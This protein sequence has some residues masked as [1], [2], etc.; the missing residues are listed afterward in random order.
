M[1]CC[2]SATAAASLA[3]SCMPPTSRSSSVVG[4][5]VSGWVCEEKPGW[6]RHR[7]SRP[8]MPSSASPAQLWPSAAL[9]TSTP[10]A[11]PR[12]PPLPLTLHNQVGKVAQQ[13]GRRGRRWG[14]M[15]GCVRHCRRTGRDSRTGARARPASFC[16]PCPAPPRPPVHLRREGAA[17]EVHDAQRAVAH[18]VCMG[19]GGWAGG[20]RE[21]VEVRRA[22]RAQAHVEEAFRCWL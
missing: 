13:A 6:A 22:Q 14:G 9:C 7:T 2:P 11:L 17:L 16:A 21:C 12:H 19:A 5:W 20:R 10:C 4:G 8:A 15:E 3:T 1:R 18:A